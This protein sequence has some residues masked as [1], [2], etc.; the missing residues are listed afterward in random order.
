MGNNVFWKRFEKTGRIEDYLEY[1]C[2]C[3]ADTEDELTGEVRISDVYA[4]DIVSG[5]A[6]FPAWDERIELF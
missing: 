5:E 4:G 1:A 6:R 3:E 2:T